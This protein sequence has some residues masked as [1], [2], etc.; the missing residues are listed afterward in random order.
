MTTLLISLDLDPVRADEVVR[1]LRGEMAPWMRQQTGYLTSHWFLADDRQHCTITVEFEDRPQASDVAQATL[2]LPSN[3]DRSWNVG[4]VEI[5]D[6]LGL[7][8]RPGLR[9]EG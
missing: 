7:A 3:T 1:L 4:R 2:A 9:L 8:P 6:D 5:V